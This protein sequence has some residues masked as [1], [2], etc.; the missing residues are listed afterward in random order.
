M[1]KDAVG[2]NAQVIFTSRTY[3]QPVILPLVP[4][5]PATAV[6]CN[7]MIQVSA[8]QILHDQDCTVGLQARSDELHNV[9]VMAALQ[10][11]YLLLEDI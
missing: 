7:G 5:E 10:D 1:Q 11:G 9:A 4:A 6:I 8:L 2:P 3:C